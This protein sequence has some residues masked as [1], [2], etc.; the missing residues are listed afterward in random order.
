MVIQ[1]ITKRIQACFAASRKHGIQVKIILR[2][3][4]EE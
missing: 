3:N 2:K 1:F 4:S